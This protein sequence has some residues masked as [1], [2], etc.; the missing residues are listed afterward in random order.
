[1]IK[2]KLIF[3]SLKKGAIELPSRIMTQMESC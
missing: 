1:M 2:L 3:F